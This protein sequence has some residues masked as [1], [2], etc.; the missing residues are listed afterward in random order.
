MTTRFEWDEAKNRQNQAKHGVTFDIAQWAFMDPRRV[1]AE[2]LE[3]SES[4]KR[5]Y[6]FG[7]AAGGVMTV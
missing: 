2:D 6:C 7:R 5:Y 3:H 1:I 4:E